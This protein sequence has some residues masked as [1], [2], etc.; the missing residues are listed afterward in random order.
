MYVLGS[1]RELGD[2]T[3][4]AHALMGA[5]AAAGRPDAIFF[6]GEETEDSLRAVR[7]AGYRGK[8]ER[9]LEIGALRDAV[10]PWLRDGDLV[11]LKASR[12]LALE[13]LADEMAKAGLTGTLRQ[14]SD[15]HAS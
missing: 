13:R 3:A 15:H 10:I 4:K 8:A 1:M 9:H 2:E 11:L 7:E 6:F 14:G 12:S 5:R